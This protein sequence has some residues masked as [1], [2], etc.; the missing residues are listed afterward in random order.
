MPAATQRHEVARVL[1]VHVI[2]QHK[3]SLPHCKTA[4]TCLP[5]SPG[6]ASIMSSPSSVMQPGA[7]SSEHS[8]MDRQP[9][10]PA[11]LCRRC[12]GV[13]SPLPAGCCCRRCAAASHS[14][15]SSCRQLAGSCSVTA[16]SGRAPRCSSSRPL[17]CSMSRSSSCIFLLLLLLLPLAVLAGHACA[18]TGTAARAA[19]LNARCTPWLCGPSLRADTTSHAPG[20]S[21]STSLRA[22]AWLLCDCS[23]HAEAL[24]LDS[25]SGQPE[26]QQL[27]RAAAQHTQQRARVRVARH[28]RLRRHR[29]AKQLLLPYELEQHTGVGTR[30]QQRLLRCRCVAEA[31]P[32]NAQGAERAGPGR[33]QAV[34]LRAEDGCWQAALRRAQAGAACGS[35]SA[36][37]RQAGL[38]AVCVCAPAAS[39]PQHQHAHCC[40]RCSPLGC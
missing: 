32:Q 22:A 3:Q 35:S 15:C 14:A 37:S 16:T 25:L 34:G 4:N 24:P 33:L 27:R 5:C 6:D 17:G 20:S 9:R 28:A 8:D 36:Y 12:A 30:Q 19:R 13:S 31:G 21:C 26:G 38:S 39:A 7:S 1:A 11:V 10:L 29:T 2:H 18:A 40:R 23:M